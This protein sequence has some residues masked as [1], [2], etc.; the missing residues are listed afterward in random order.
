[1]KISPVVRHKHV[2][3]RR[4][5]AAGVSLVAIAV[6][7]LAN[8]CGGGDSG[9]TVSRPTATAVSKASP[10]ASPTTVQIA[11]G[12]GHSASAFFNSPSADGCI[13]TNVAVIGVSGAEKTMANDGPARYATTDLFIFVNQFDVCRNL[14]LLSAFGDNPQ[15]TIFEESP[16]L[17]D[18][19]VVG[20]VTLHDTISITNFDIQID[21]SWTA[22]GPMSGTTAATLSPSFPGGVVNTHFIGRSRQAVASGAVVFNATN[23]AP[24]ASVFGELD[25][26]N[27]GE[28]DST[29]V[30]R[31]TSATPTPAQCRPNVAVRCSQL[32]S[33]L[34][35]FMS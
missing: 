4:W 21:V 2:I 6:S 20:V 18:A 15:P 17:G 16:E 10:P 12:N 11:M 25:T 23:Y 34:T 27:A 29:P 22:S 13:S 33:L 26:G 1:M 28:I 35:R 14:L 31:S 9:G 32:R 19:H 30:A 7:L 3:L 24:V 5:R 8:S